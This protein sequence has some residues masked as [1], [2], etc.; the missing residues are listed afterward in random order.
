MR[1]PSRGRLGIVL[2]A[3]LIAGCGQSPTGAPTA[4][5][6]C[7]QVEFPSVQ[8]GSHLLGDSQPPIPYSSTP[9]TSGWHSSGAVPE[10]VFTEPLPEPAQVS[11]LEAG[12]VV[13]THNG[14]ADEDLQRLTDAVRERFAD[15]VV[16][17]PYDQIPA[18]S[19][20]FTSWGVLQTCEG[21]DLEAL[22][23]FVAAYGSPISSH[24]A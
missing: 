9:P 22:A 10:G 11:V 12:G 24:D 8:F 2:T 18:G 20:A 19:T 23:A 16:V 21:L 17:T 14:L 15:R 3:V 4:T 7:D 6:R 5:D 13:V 1:T